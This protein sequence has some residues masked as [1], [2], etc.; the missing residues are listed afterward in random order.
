MAQKSNTKTI[1]LSDE[2]LDLIDRQNGTTFTER[3][4]TLVTKC[5]WE[6]P[7]KEKEL[8][9]LEEEIGKKRE[10]LVATWKQTQQLEATLNDLTY[11][12]QNFRAAV[13]RALQKWE[14]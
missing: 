4:E 5:V 12:M 8:E 7:A 14:S 13:D 9:R 10:Q 6:I 2:M 11:R 3:F 1:R